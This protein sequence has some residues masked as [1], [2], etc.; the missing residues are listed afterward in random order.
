MVSSAFTYLAAASTLL[1]AASAHMIMSTPVP[2]GKS[3]L[4]NSPLDPSGSDF[5]C[6]QRSGVYEAQGASN[7]AAVGATVKLAFTGSA[8]HGGGSCQISLTSDKAPSKTSKWMVIHSIEGGC[9]AK[10]QAGNGAASDYS[11]SIPAGVAAGEYTLAWTWFN[12][13]GNREMYMNCAP[14]TVTGGSKRSVEARKESARMSRRADSFPAMF[15]ANI[16]GSTCITKESVDLQFPDPGANVDKFGKPADLKLATC[17][18]SGGA[19]ASSSSSSSSSG[20]SSPP[21]PP[22]SSAAPATSAA[23]AAPAPVVQSTPS[24]APAAPAPAPAAPAP[25]APA[26]AD[27]APA[28]AAPAP[29]APAAPASG[30]SCSSPGALVCSSDGT[31]FGICA[32]TSAVMMA[33]AAGTKCSGG[34]IMA[35]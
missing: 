31:Q 17:A 32:G 25:A 24:A 16:C 3:S 34:A 26:P 14:F 33:V 8:V 13:V 20:S 10:G 21:P 27:P 23:P 6:K 1:S 28:P 29:A 7:S 2:Y 30:A 11:F 5:P 35:A 18:C 15:T 19:A 12:K 22:P 4:N 9:P